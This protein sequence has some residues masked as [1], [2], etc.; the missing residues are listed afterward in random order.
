M[1]IIQSVVITDKRNKMKLNIGCGTNIRE[2]YVNLDFIKGKGVDVVHNL[3]EF[4][5]PFKDNT[6]EYIYASHILEHLTPT[7]FKIIRELVRIS[8]DKAII[9]I[10][11]PHYTSTSCFATV[12]IK[13][14]NY[15]SFSSTDR[16]KSL[17]R[18]YEFRNITTQTRIL[19]DKRLFFN[20]IIEPIMNKIPR[21]YENTFL[22]YLFPAACYEFKLEVVK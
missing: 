21:V 11:V 19:F 10:I 8:K 9:E 13:T 3:N 12:H 2:G 7:I 18:E 5:Y 4:P 17:E 1:K 20:Y 14:F 6:F 22:K 15:N 16:N